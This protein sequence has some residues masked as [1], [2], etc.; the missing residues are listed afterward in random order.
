MYIYFIC[1]HKPADITFNFTVYQV[2]SN[3]Y[4]PYI[5]E[6]TLH[7]IKYK[8]IQI[9]SKIGKLLLQNV[10]TTEC[11]SVCTG[12]TISTDLNN[13]AP[14]AEQFQTGFEL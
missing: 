14:V 4:P 10:S 3:D 9:C 2:V 1:I 12:K 13:V 8:Y 11:V 6:S 5:L 7:Y